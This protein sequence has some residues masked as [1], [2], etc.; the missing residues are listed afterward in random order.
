MH[1]LINCAKQHMIIKICMHHVVLN[2]TRAKFVSG[3]EQDQD[4][5]GAVQNR[6]CKIETSH[7][8]YIYFQPN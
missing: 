4:I 1:L 7:I 2:K 5:Q 3:L 8:D 6:G